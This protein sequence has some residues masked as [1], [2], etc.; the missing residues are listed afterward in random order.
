M[1]KFCTKC[2]KPLEDGKKCDCEKENKT[3]E[4]VV[5]NNLVDG[6]LDIFKRIFVNPLKTVKKYANGNN[7]AK[8][9][10][11]I[12]AKKVFIKSISAPNDKPIPKILLISPSA[13]LF[14][15]K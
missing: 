11:K 4:Q 10:P 12:P 14:K 6:S 5:E 15:R 13:K 8:A 1:A 2:G 9:I 7:N 3:E